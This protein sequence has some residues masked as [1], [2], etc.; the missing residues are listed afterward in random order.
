M[1]MPAVC[2][3]LFYKDKAKSYGAFRQEASYVFEPEPDPYTEFDSAEKNFECTKRPLIMGLWAAWTVYGKALFADRIEH[4]CG[5][6]GEAYRI[7]R[8][9]PDFEPLHRPEAN[10]LC[11][12]YR[13]SALRGRERPDF[14]AA[15]RNRIREG[16]KFFLSKVDI[17]GTAALRVVFMNHRT[18]LDH[19]RGLLDEIR[20]TGSELR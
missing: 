6:A 4:L 5:L 18:D 16:G 17:D 12:R 11:F 9:E 1:F 14:Q 15:I 20:K 19:F 7:L 3:L 10:I 13:P 2:T 8:D